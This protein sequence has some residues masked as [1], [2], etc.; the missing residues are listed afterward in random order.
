MPLF[1]QLTSLLVYHKPPNPR[2]FLIEQ[3]SAIQRETTL[4]DLD[5]IDTF[6]MFDTRDLDALFRLMDPAESG[7][8]TNSQVRMALADMRA[9]SN[10]VQ[11]QLENGPERFTAEQFRA[12]SFEGLRKER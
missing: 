5:K 7:Y 11:S 8:V 10:D 12:L 2:A 1:E 6:S 4:A 3:L 9:L